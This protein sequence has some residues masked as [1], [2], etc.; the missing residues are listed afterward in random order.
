MLP[1]PEH[2]LKEWGVTVDALSRG[3]QVLILRKGGIGEKRFEL[4][5]PRF[6][7]F[8][9]YAHQRPELVKQESRDR[10][11]ASLDRRDD[12]ERLPLPAYAEIAAS[13]AVTEHVQLEALDHLHILTADYAAERLRWRRTHPLWAVAL[14]VW[15]LD[16]PPALDVSAEHLGCVSW[17]TLPEGMIP[18]AMTPALQDDAFAAAVADVE[19]ALERVAGAAA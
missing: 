14:R 19:D 4:P 17:V 5:H 2:A 1:V 11:A 3:D 13:F 8:P 9:T 16:N 12:P 18:G 10:L 7:L 6:F 15:R